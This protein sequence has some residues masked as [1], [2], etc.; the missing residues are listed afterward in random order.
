MTRLLLWRHGRTAWNAEHRLQGQTD[1]ELDETGIAQAVDSALAL[2]AQEPK[3]IISSDL[4][5]ATR[6]AQE[7]VGLTGL[8]VRLDPRLR[9][10]F[11]GPWQGFTGEEIRAR[12]PDE[13]RRWGPGSVEDHP[14]FEPVPAMA[15]RVVA[16]LRE[17]AEE[18][19][20]GATA[21]LVTHGG[22]A[23]VGIGAMLGWPPDQWQTLGALGN[24]QVTALRR[25]PY[26]GWQLESY[27]SQPR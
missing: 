1:V 23:R 26:R 5:R 22:A 4:K 27:N 18:A 25:S 7:L 21:V 15:E 9:E 2:A 20:E 8:P 12:F 3:L 11:F 6:T 10:R 16:A 17:A 24:C 14:G 19:G 13:Y